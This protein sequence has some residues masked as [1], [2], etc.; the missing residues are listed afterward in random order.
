MVA[1][2]ANIH[3]TYGAFICNVAA[4]LFVCRPGSAIGWHAREIDLYLLYTAAQALLQGHAAVMHMDPD[5]QT[6]KLR[7][8]E[9]SVFS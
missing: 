4:A 1:I 2:G 7:V 9:I 6:A 5:I 3:G 8:G